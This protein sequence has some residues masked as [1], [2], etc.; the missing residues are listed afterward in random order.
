MS[1]LRQILRFGKKDGRSAELLTQRGDQLAQAGSHREAVEA[2]KESIERDAHNHS[3]YIKLAEAHYNLGERAEADAVLE[4]LVGL[5]PPSTNTF[6]EV[7]GFYLST[8]QWRQAQEMA[9]KCVALGTRDSNYYLADSVAASANWET[10]RVIASACR[11]VELDP[12]N[13]DAYYVLGVWYEEAQNDE[14]ISA[15]KKSIE[16]NPA[17]GRAEFSLAGRYFTAGKYAE[18]AETYKGIIDRGSG[19]NN[20]LFQLANTYAYLG[21]YDDALNAMRRALG[22]YWDCLFISPA[23]YAQTTKA[24]EH[25]VT[26]DS[27]PLRGRTTCLFAAYISFFFSCHANRMDGIQQGKAAVAASLGWYEKALPYAEPAG[28]RDALE[29][30]IHYHVGREYAGSDVWRYD[31]ACEALQRSVALHP[32]WYG[33]HEM[34]E[35][36]FP[37]ASLSKYA[38]DAGRLEQAID[39]LQ[40]HLSLLRDTEQTARER[41]LDLKAQNLEPDDPRLY[42]SSSVLKHCAEEETKST[43]T[44]V[45]LLIKREAGTRVGQ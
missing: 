19:N 5:T 18:S 40:K 20:T 22:N 21:R 16:I 15:L 23:L 31:D 25:I 33:T 17:N 39:A 30:Q 43:R 44:L 10:E 29:W 27:D 34:V 6:R 24:L 35:G 7:I 13:A 42:E 12:T 11:S 1:W 41:A 3:P 38:L 14:A 4:K 8:D 2:Y 36:L 37:L 28:E 9:A 26:S 45:E 32:G